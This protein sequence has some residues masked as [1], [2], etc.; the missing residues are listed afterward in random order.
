MS[1]ADVEVLQRI[2]E[3]YLATGEVDF[4]TI[5]PEVE[6]SDHDIPESGRYRGH[7]GWVRWFGELEEAWSEF[8]AVIDDFIDAGDR[9]VLLLT[10]TATGRSSRIELT[11]EDAIVY[12]LRDGKVFRLD[13]FNDRAQA[14]DFA[15]LD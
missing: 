2:W 5:H 8:D 4:E 7:D 1:R 14:L 10:L 15:G 12:E 6:I 3:A 11:R 9:I 13:Y